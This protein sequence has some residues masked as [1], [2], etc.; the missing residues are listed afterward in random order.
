MKMSEEKFIETLVDQGVHIA[1]F[2][3]VSK[4]L[5]GPDKWIVTLF[6]HVIM[7]FFKEEYAVHLRKELME[8]VRKDIENIA[9]NI[10]VFE[11]LDELHDDDEIT[12]AVK[13][14]K[15]L[16]K[17]C[18]TCGTLPSRARGCPNCE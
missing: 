2:P 1:Y 6:G 15:E 3:T 10:K 17:R 7:E 11:K 12:Q 18:E 4:S 16:M 9:L 8:T 13:K 5:A 14:Q